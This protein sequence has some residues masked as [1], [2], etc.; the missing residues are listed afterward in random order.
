MREG[1]QELETE[2]RATTN[3]FLADLDSSTENTLRWQTTPRPTKYIYMSTKTKD[4]YGHNK[5]I[6]SATLSTCS[7]KARVGAWR[8]DA[9]LDDTETCNYILR[10][11]SF[12]GQ[13]TSVQ[14]RPQLPQ[15]AN[16]NGLATRKE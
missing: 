8:I 2:G 3:D 10:M 12:G 9:S 7:T 4:G 16:A 6:L 14:G 1:D 11:F 15:R 5:N 13:E